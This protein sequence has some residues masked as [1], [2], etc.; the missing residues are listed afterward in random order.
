MAVDIKVEFQPTKQDLVCI[1]EDIQ[2]R[3]KAKS[4]RF[5]NII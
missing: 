1:I 3:G 4:R 2:D 5:V